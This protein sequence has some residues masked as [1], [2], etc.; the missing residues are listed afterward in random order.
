MKEQ[1]L[2]GQRI[3]RRLR[4]GNPKEIII[5]LSQCYYFRLAQ[6]ERVKVILKIVALSGGIGMARYFH[7]KSSVAGIESPIL[8]W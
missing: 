1:W 4:R 7:A 2:A 6:A 3:G 5:D 8:L